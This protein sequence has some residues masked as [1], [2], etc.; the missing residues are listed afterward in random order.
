MGR[1]LDDRIHHTSQFELLDNLHLLLAFHSAVWRGVFFVVA[2]E[3]IPLY[4]CGYTW[5]VRPYCRHRADHA[6]STKNLAWTVTLYR[7]RQS[8]THLDSGSQLQDAVGTKQYSG[9]ADVLCFSFEPPLSADLLVADG[10]LNQEALGPAEHLRHCYTR[11][12]QNHFERSQQPRLCQ[13]EARRHC[14]HNPNESYVVLA[15]RVPPS[16]Q[17]AVAV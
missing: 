6:S 13:P 2:D 14:T 9:P 17:N 5:P 15:I 10:Q 11:I 8:E 3:V 12:E 16:K 4:A 1:D 7:Y